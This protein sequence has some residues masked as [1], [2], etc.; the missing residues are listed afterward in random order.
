MLLLAV[1]LPLLLHRMVVSLLLPIVDLALLLLL[2]L[3]PLH[4]SSAHCPPLWPP[5]WQKKQDQLPVTS[6]GPAAAAH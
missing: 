2:L 6:M 4:R 5:L 1:L 3:L